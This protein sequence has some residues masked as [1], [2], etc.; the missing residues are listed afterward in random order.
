MNHPE[1]V[2]K[3]IFIQYQGKVNI[4]P[5]LTDAACWCRSVHDPGDEIIE[6]RENR[7]TVTQLF[8]YLYFF[9]LFSSKGQFAFSMTVSSVSEPALKKCSPVLEAT[10]QEAAQA[11][12]HLIRKTGAVVCVWRDWNNLV[13]GDKT[14]RGHFCCR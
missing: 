14:P 4:W 9:F 5:L 1:W 10:L 11:S 7:C 13:I 2:W 3:T 12:S 8:I 6:L